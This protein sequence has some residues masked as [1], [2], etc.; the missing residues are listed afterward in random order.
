MGYAVTVFARGRRT[1]CA[2]SRPG[3]GFAASNGAARFANAVFGGGAAQT[4][5]LRGIAAAGAV[6]K[7]GARVFFDFI[8]L[9]AA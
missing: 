6:G 5:A 1:V 9:S 2:R 3:T 4:G 7:A 8:F